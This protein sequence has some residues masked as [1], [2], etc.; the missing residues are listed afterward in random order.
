MIASEA[1]K[2]TA[3]RGVMTLLILTTIGAVVLVYAITEIFHLAQPAKYP[4]VG[5]DPGFRRI[6]DIMGRIGLIPAA[7]LGATAGAQDVEAGV[8]RDMFV[9]GRPRWLIYLLRNVGATVVW[10]PL[11]VIAYAIGILATFVFSNGFPEP[12]TAQIF[13]GLGYVVG[14]SLSFVLVTLGIATLF[15][16]R[17]PAIAV[18][19]GWIII[20]EGL[21]TAVTFLGNV[22]EAFFSV[23]SGRL[24]PQIGGGVQGGPFGTLHPSLVM[25]IVTIV[26]WAVVAYALGNWRTSRLEA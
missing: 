22:R 13:Q 26:A 21:L 11:I 17:G 2:I 9:T 1:R 10:V 4:T 16:S 20:A 12:N 5:G 8:I 23:A 14:V 25:A 18:A 24:A 3:R 15:G 6:V 7:I 19:I